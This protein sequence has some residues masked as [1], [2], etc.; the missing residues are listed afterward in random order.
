MPFRISFVLSKAD[1]TL[2]LPNT[3]KILTLPILAASFALAT[4]AM[5]DP[6]APAGKADTDKA[7]TEATTSGMGSMPMGQ[8]DRT[9]TCSKPMD[10]SACTMHCG[11]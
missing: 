2:R 4:M 9:S 7:K 5:A 11:M 8:G 1:T 10:K 6:T 3:M